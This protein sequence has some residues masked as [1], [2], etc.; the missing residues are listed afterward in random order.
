MAKCTQ[1]SVKMGGMFGA[2]EADDDLYKEAQNLGFDLPKSICVGC[3]Q[4]LINKAK[5]DGDTKS[6][7][8]QLIENKNI[9]KIFIT[10]AQLPSEF[11]DMG[12]VTG[13]SILGTGPL[14]ELYSSISD[15]AGQESKIYNDKIK[16]A[17][18]NCIFRIKEEAYKKGCN[19]IYNIHISVT[20]AT[21][22]HGMIMVSIFGTAAKSK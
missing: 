22:G 13:Y 10:P 16:K 18:S 21:S 9:E 7:Q 3:A 8:A 4:K 11:E 15:M 2:V 1:C 6:I 5:R 17:E 12:L 20:E 14:S 19:A